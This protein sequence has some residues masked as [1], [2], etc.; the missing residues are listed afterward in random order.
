MVNA[1]DDE[2]DGP[3]L[4]LV[5]GHPFDRSM[6]WPQLDHFRDRYRVVVPDLRGYGE[7]AGASG[8]TPLPAFA[9]DL[10]AL[11]DRLAIDRAVVWGLSMGGQI[12]MELHRSHPER[13]R[14]LVLADTTHE[15]DE[16]AAARAR[17]E[18]A[19]RVE[20][21]GIGPY[22]EELM[23]RM[24]SP[25]T[26][27]EQPDVADHVRRMM[28]GAPPAGAAAALRGR[29]AR[30]D[31]TPSL[32]SARV[33]V[34]VVVGEEDEF[35]PVATARRLHGTVPGSALAVVPR[36]GH[37]PNLEQPALFNRVVEEFLAGLPDR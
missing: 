23:R 33:P 9:D 2:G 34:L 14:A 3:P 36:A 17:H 29:A 27:V 19:D 24:I 31:Y 15:A 16:P 20:R 28:R 13:V 12:T 6:W 5:H 10:V 30:P 21:E 26:A 35:T 11:L 18:T 32:A 8:T 1:Y 37:L 22:A 25:R 4:L 7:A